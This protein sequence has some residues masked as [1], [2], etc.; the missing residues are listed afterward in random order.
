MAGRAVIDLVLIAILIGYAVSG[1][2]QGLV[3]GAC[4]LGGFIGGALLAMWVVPPL[5]TGLQAGVQRSMIVLIAVLAAAWFGQFLGSL[6]GVR[7]RR[8]LSERTEE[9]LDKGLGAVAGVLAV[10]LVMWFVAGA[11]RGGPS[12]VLSRAVASSRVIAAIDSVM[13]DRLVGVADAFRGVVAGSS[14]PRVFAGVGREDITAVTAP[15]PGSVDQA[16][17]DRVAPSIVKITGS[18]SCARDQEGSGAVV[19]PER[20]VTNAHVVAGVRRPSVESANGHHYQGTVV[21]FDARRDIAVLAVPGLPAPPLDFGNALHRADS[22]VVA[23][24]PNDGPFSATPARV[25]SVLRAS[26]DDIYGGP[27]AVR[28][29]YSLYARV[30]PG[31]SGGPVLSSGGQLVGVVFARS[32]DD[33]ATGYAL[34]LAEADPVIQAG[35]R[36]GQPVSTGGCALG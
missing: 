2:R 26:G 5:A 32:L 1:Y 31:N 12:P 14:F 6:G 19:A 24:F 33:E 15:D 27:G 28:Q 4:S 13:P 23:G 11:L 10:A 7:L 34:T 20:V 21:A 25:R 36:A 18:A 17:I 3:V 9:P 30:E 22:A 29:V 35:I 8:Q 16:V